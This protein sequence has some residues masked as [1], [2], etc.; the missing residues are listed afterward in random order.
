[1]QYST[2]WLIFEK[3][4]INVEVLIALA[5]LIWKTVKAPIKRNVYFLYLSAVTILKPVFPCLL[6]MSFTR[7]TLISFAS[8][9]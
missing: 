6:N 2:W 3:K 1:M 4:K 5:K 7:T 8:Q 9:Y